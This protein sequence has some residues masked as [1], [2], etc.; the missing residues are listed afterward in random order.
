MRVVR[1]IAEKSAWWRRWSDVGLPLGL[2][3]C[4]ALLVTALLAI[5]PRLSPL[6]GLTVAVAGGMAIGWAGHQ[7]RNGRVGRVTTDEWAGALPPGYR[8]LHDVELPGMTVDHVVIAPTG[9][10]VIANL[11]QR[12]IVQ[13]VADGLTIDGRRLLRDPRRRMQTA[14]TGVRER[15]QRELGMPIRVVPL[16]CFGR[17]TVIGRSAG[18]DVAVVSWQNMLTTLRRGSQGVP[19]AT[20]ARI[21]RALLRDGG[22]PA[23]PRMRLV[24]GAT[25]TAPQ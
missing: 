24:G 12:G 23:H 17:A 19:A 16:L 7:G 20:R 22:R 11:K 6:V 1:A 25:A 10:W 21:R 5:L 14:A 15:L 2:G 13:L 8:I 18:S 9:V 3:A 4:A